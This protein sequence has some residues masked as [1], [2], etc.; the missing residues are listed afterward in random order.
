MVSCYLKGRLANQGFI[1]AATIAYALRHRLEW[2]IPSHTNNNTAWPPMFTHL[3]HPNWNPDLPTVYINEK[4][5]S[6]EALPFEDSWKDY[7]IMIGSLDVTS[8]YFQSEDYFSDFKAY[9]AFAMLHL[10]QERGELPDLIIRNE[11]AIHLRGGDYLTY[12]KHHPPV[13]PE[14]VKKAV[15]FMNSKGLNSFNVF[16]DDISWASGLLSDISR[17]N[18]VSVVSTNDPMLDFRSIVTHEGIITSNSTFSLLAAILNPRPDKVIVSPSKDN[19]YG[20]LNAHLSTDTI[21]P[22][23]INQIK[24]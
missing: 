20:E 3:T 10:E 23:Y 24:Y 5:H 15:E 12:S 7:N 16:T 1:I 9:V 17:E 4:S 6:Y 18:K 22:D 13:T 11:C 8:G 21:L 19:W 2:H 14:Y